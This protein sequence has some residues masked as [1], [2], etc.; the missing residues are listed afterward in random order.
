MGE[1]CLWVYTVF[2]IEETERLEDVYQ[3]FHFF[4]REIFDSQDCED[5][6]FEKRIWKL[7][8]S[9][10]NLYFLKYKYSYLKSLRCSALYLTVKFGLCDFQIFLCK[11]DF[12]NI[13]CGFRIPNLR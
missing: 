9:K 11:L 4:L 7:I 10:F 6:L 3:F 13:L 12:L 2:Y 5:P 1:G 8:I